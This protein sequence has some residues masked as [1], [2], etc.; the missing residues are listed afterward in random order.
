MIDNFNL[1]R[2]LLSFDLEDSFYFVQIIQR[3]KD[4]GEIRYRSIRDYTFNS[5]EQFEL[6]KEEIIHL[7]NSLSARAYIN[8]NRRL[9]RAVCA[10]MLGSLTRWFQQ[11]SFPVP[12]SL[13][14]SACGRSSSPD[15]RWVLDLDDS[16]NLHESDIVEYLNDL[17]PVGEK[18]ICRVPTPNG[19]HLITS[20]FD[21]LKFRARYPKVALPKGS[22]T[23]LY[24][25]DFPSLPRDSTLGEGSPFTIPFSV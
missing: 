5:Q 11:N 13:Y 2:P 14:S 12:H 18:V 4:V 10:E 17:R 15:S 19:C 9:N 16:L 6:R 21:S 8:L 23:L 22:L 1:L 20:P 7:C 3:P 25:P 24:C